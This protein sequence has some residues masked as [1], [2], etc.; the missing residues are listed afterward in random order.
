MVLARATSWRLSGTVSCWAKT[1]AAVKRTARKNAAFF[2]TVHLRFWLQA[3]CGT[4]LFCVVSDIVRQEAA[5]AGL[6]R[7]IGRWQL[8]VSRR[9]NNTLPLV[10]RMARICID[11]TN[12]FPVKALWGQNE[13]CRNAQIAPRIQIDQQ[14][15]LR[16]VPACWPKVRKAL[17]VR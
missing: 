2:I 12:L 16:T 9:E 15:Q 4:Q 10:T 3:H 13:N 5:K 11:S 8:P 14:R 1:R 7:A 6:K 17:R